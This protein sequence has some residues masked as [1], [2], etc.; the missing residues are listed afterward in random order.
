MSE[1]TDF[2]V[3]WGAAMTVAEKQSASM[4]AD[5]A[6]DFARSLYDEYVEQ[7]SPKNKKKWLTERLK[8]EFLCLQGKPI[9]V[10]EPSWFFHQGKPM[11]FLHQVLVSPSAQ[12][13]KERI[14][15]GD[16]VYVFGSKHLLKRPTGDVWTDIYR[17]IVQTYEGETAVEIL[18]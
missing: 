3:F 9:W 1:L 4:D 7:G 6:E 16:T 18:E 10:G 5:G 2:H 17:T 8:D 12:H 14:S 15:L 13:I 11:V